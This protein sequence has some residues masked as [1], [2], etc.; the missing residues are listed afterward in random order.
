MVD[1]IN[2][3]QGGRSVHE[4]F[5]EFRKFSKYATCFVFNPRDQMSGFVTGVSED[6][7]EE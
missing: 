4:Y 3:R 7:Q 6:I 5:L 2:L 1:F